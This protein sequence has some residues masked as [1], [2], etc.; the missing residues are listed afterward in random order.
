V[1]AVILMAA[2]PVEAGNFKLN[3]RPS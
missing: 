1:V 3:L 2:E